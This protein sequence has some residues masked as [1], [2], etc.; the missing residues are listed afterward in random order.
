MQRP[1]QSWRTALTGLM[2]GTQ[3]SYMEIDQSN[4]RLYVMSETDVVSPKRR[5]NIS[6]DRGATWRRNDW[7]VDAFAVDTNVPGTL[8]AAAA[9]QFFKSTDYG[10]TWKT[11]LNSPPGVK[12]IR[13]VPG[14]PNLAFTIGAIYPEGSLWRSADSGLSWTAVKYHR[15]LET[16]VGNLAISEDGKTVFAVDDWGWLHKSTDEGVTWQESPVNAVNP[17]VAYSDVHLEPGNKDHVYIRSRQGYGAYESRD[18]G[19]TWTRLRGLSDNV[20]CLATD[21]R[22]PAWVIAGTDSGLL[23]SEDRGASW[24][25]LN[26]GFVKG[27]ITAVR[28]DPFD[29]RH[30]YAL[31]SAGLLSYTRDPV[32]WVPRLSSPGGQIGLAFA[33]PGPAQITTKLTALEAAGTNLV[34]PGGQNPVAIELDAGGQQARI[35][36]EAFGTAAPSLGDGWLRAEAST[37]SCLG[38][39]S[40][41]TADLAMLD[42]WEVLRSPSRFQLLP[43]VGLDGFARLHL[44]NPG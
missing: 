26:A 10:T 6:D 1:S 34:I 41:F 14:R 39:F 30:I 21:S 20:S 36:V 43:E 12:Q 27:P 13:L 38:M 29:S 5:V 32:A 44:A 8:Y 23:L 35:D 40:W 28:L 4:G 17:P 18:G 11:G 31:T 37:L 3:Q 24:S 42:T 19:A 7:A 16:T 2:A 25:L 15:F 33:N 22:N 9:Q